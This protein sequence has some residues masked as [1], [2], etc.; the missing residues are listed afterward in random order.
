MHLQQPMADAAGPRFSE[1]ESSLKLDCPETWNFAIIQPLGRFGK[2]YATPEFLRPLL[3]VYIGKRNAFGAIGT[4][5]A[6][7]STNTSICSECNYRNPKLTCQYKLCS[8]CCSNKGG[9]RNHASASEGKR[10]RSRRKSR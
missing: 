3:P 10:R 7:R 1:M 2:C 6:S 9:C 8:N 4:K 5:N